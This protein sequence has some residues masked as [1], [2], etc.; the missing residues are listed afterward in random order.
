MRQ[1]Y[2]YR[3]SGKDLP[4]IG[5]QILWQ[6]TLAF[7]TNSPADDGSKMHHAGLRKMEDLATMVFN[8]VRD[9]F[10]GKKNITLQE[11]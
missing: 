1:R 7:P 3:K 11:P 10:L 8:T 6:L 5:L 2:A 9:T 4:L